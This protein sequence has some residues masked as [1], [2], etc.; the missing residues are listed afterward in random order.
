[1]KRQS[2]KPIMVKAAEFTGKI[3]E[4]RELQEVQSFGDLQRPP[5]SSA[6]Y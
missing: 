3:L 4:K 2:W 6:E 5:E 1:M